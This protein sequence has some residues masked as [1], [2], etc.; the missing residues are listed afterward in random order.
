MVTNIFSKKLDSA[1]TLFKNE[2][3]LY[4]DFAPSELVGRESIIQTLASIISPAANGMR[5]SNVFVYGPPG[6]GKTICCKYVLSQLSEYSS[7]TLP[8]YVNCWQNDSRQSVLSLISQKAGEVL[9]RR[10]ISSQEVFSRTLESLWQQ[11]KIP[12]IV[13][14]EADRLFWGGED[15]LL[16]DLARTWETSKVHSCVILVTNDSELLSKADARVRSSMIGKEIE[17]KAYTPLELK[18]IVESRAKIALVDGTYDS[19]V[20]ALCAAAGARANGDARVSLQA[21][22]LAAR[23]AN[24][25][26]HSKISVDDAKKA[27]AAQPTSAQIKRERDEQFLEEPEKKL[28]SLIVEQGGSISLSKLYEA[29][30]KKYGASERSIRNYLRKLEFKGLL[31]TQSTDSNDDQSNSKKVVKVIE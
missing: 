7:K 17:F 1:T 20:I 10:G 16:Y 15:K 12:V 30:S 5:A 6:T 23:N 13:L 28:I 2:Q 29:Y 22:W 27:F 24:E 21:L 18:K 8:I 19:E 14:D 9:P 4:P 3:A 26:G 11:K 25:A 31:S